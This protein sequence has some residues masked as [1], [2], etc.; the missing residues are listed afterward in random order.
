MQESTAVLI[1]GAG[2]TGLMAA[3]QLA[4]LGIKFRIIDK[5]KEPTTQSRALAIHAASMEI[6]SQMGISDEFIA[7]GKQTKAI[8]YLVK[9]KVTEHIPLSAFG[10]GLTAFPFLLM[11][12]QSRTE[13]LLVN[14]LEKQGYEVEWETELIAF[15]QDT[16]A[17]YV[18]VKHN[19]RNEETIKASWLIGADGAK[20]IVRRILN[21]PFGGET[22]PI[23]LFVLDCKVNWQLQDDEIYIAFSNYSFAGFFPMPENRCRIIGFVPKDIGEKENISFEDI[24][25]GFAER[26][27]MKVELSDP[28]WISMYH[29]HHRY[30]SQFRTGRCFLAGDAAHIHS[31][32]GAQGMN[33]GLQDANNIAW[34]LA[35]VIRNQAKE[36]LLATYQQ[37]RLPFARQLVKTTDNAFGITVSKNPFI[38]I[39]RMYVAPKIL[40]LIL[41]VNFITRYIFKNISQIG[42]N[43]PDSL[44]SKNASYGSFVSK[45]P[46][47]GERLPYLAFKDASGKTFGMQQKVNG[48]TLHL[49]IFS[50]SDNKINVHLLSNIAQRFKE[51]I[52]IEYISLISGNE[53]LYKSLGIKRT[54]C[55]LIRPDFHIA[56]RSIGFNEKHFE[57]YLN[58]ILSNC[59]IQTQP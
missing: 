35:L 54:G 51:A 36:N 45:A 29:S 21:I 39:M 28:K 9:G 17:V 24:K 23:N 56:Y 57:N 26:M 47:P 31:P 13:R 38:K 59:R 7:L 43:Y 40:A 33:T 25:K 42:M 14:F 10:K 55:Y 11:L 8:N 30:V 6:F 2:P 5:N 12:E 52:T 15:T 49:F 22:Y 27:Q 32:V 4:R 1:V 53:I 58:A 3:C 34:K 37:E 41:K 50:G 16:N 18:T 44:L 48:L 20:S 19:E 46:K